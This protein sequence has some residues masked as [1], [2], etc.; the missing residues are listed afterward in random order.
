MKKRDINSSRVPLYRDSGFELHDASTTAGTFSAEQN[1]PHEPEMYIYSRYRNPTVV[2]AEEAIMKVEHSE[3]ALLTA[4]GMAAID[5]SLSL[6][7]EGKDTA[8]W[9][10]LSEIYGGTISYIE[11]V[12]RKKRGLDIHMFTPGGGGY[13]LG[14]L[15]E[16]ISKLK[17]SVLYAETV[18]NPLLVVSDIPAMGKIAARH[19]CKLIVDNTFASAYL[20][21]PLEHGASIVIHSATKYLGGH[22]NI[23][24]GVICGNDPGLLKAA[25][26][27]RK[28]AGH[29]ISPDDAYRLTTQVKTFELRFR[30]QCSNA[31]M[32]AG[33]FTSSPLIERVFFPE[34]STH[35]T[36]NIA[37]AILKDGLGGAMLT[38]DFGGK[39]GDQKRSRRDQ[40]IKAVSGHI[41]LIPTLGDP[42]TILMPVEAVWGAK[43]PEPGMIRISAGFEDSD[44]LK[45]VVME[46]LSMIR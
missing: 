21:R 7:Q 29:I 15:E 30:K 40:F 26:E 36:H 22:G 3:W 24:A 5:V 1:N 34:L 42:E 18:S 20:F 41:R 23:T 45:A 13:D 14:K 44:E 16:V 17:P 8:P 28:L 9:L 19:N 35:A 38:I 10:F 2:A 11:T 46:A 39:D 37:S 6:F 27:Y 32:L 12:L 33:I 43:Y 25:I 4:S 31:Q